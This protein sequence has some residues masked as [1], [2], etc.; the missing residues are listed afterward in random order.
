LIGV[1][2]LARNAGPLGKR[3]RLRREQVRIENNSER[4]V[5]AY[6]QGLVRLPP[7]PPK[8]TGI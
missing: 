1:A 7:L 2:P 4:L 6:Q 8:D 5:T 3:Q